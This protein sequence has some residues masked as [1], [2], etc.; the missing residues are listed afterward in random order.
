V[1]VTGAGGFIG[2][3]LCAAF[4]AEGRPY[5]GWVRDE[6]HAAGPSLRFVGDLHA[7]RADAIAEA[8]AG[9]SA[10]VH[11]AGRAHLDPRAS[12]AHLRLAQDNVELAQAIAG[13]ARG[14]GVS[15][16]IHLSSVKVNGDASP[17]GRPFRPD[18]P[19]APTDLYG[20]TK[21]FAEEM[22]TQQ[23][24][25]GPAKVTILRQPMVYGA[26]A[27]GNFRALVDAVEARRWLPLASIDNRRRLLSL[28]NLVDAVRAALDAPEGVPGVHF[29]GDAD[30]VSTPQL[31]RAIG[32]ALGVEPRLARVPVGLLRVAGALSG[33]S[34]T[35]AR[36]TQSLDV[37]IG[38]FTAASGWQPRP[39]R[40][41]R[42]DVGL[43][44]TR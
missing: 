21:Q 28:S 31:V 2:S 5:E 38:S 26:S 3:A 37:D 44:R 39:F 12:G 17:P 35:V 11:A 22:L 41:T 16:F 25:R 4:A 34:G 24:G 29:V 14:A 36:L 9:A 32:A 42:A 15:R 27:R 19:P 40:L 30:T 1:I 6:R 8:F 13:A 10:V 33:R 7:L 23:L 43:P 20:R 18:D